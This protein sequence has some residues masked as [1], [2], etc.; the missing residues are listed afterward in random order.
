MKNT[1]VRKFLKKGEDAIEALNALGY[2]Y[3]EP[4]KGA[5]KWV[6]PKD[7]VDEIAEAIKKLIIE[8]TPK[9]SRV[10]AP[11][12]KEMPRHLTNLVGRKFSVT[13]SRIPE[14]SKLSRFGDWHFRQRTFEAMEVRHTKNE[15]YEGY[16]VLFSF[17]THPNTPEVVWLPLSA[18][19][20]L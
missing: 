11:V 4:L 19:V 20:F 18:C 17:N 2:V 6:A 9:T 10:P 12:E 7:P 15:S 8:R 16:A 5:P 1:E 3:E 14:F 13:V